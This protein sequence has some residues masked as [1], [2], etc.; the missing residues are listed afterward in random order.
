MSGSKFTLPRRAFSRLAARMA[1]EASPD[2]AASAYGRLLDA[3]KQPTITP[4]LGKHPSLQANVK[5][6]TT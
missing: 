3:I 1:R 4:M 6:V 2:R 5:S